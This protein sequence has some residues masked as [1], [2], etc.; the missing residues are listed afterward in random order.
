MT[1]TLVSIGKK[2]KEEAEKAEVEEGALA[3]IM[4]ALELGGAA[5]N[6]ALSKDESEVLKG[7]CLLTSKPLVY[8]ANV[9]EDDLADQGASNPYLKVRPGCG[10]GARGAAE[11]AD[12]CTPGGGAKGAHAAQAGHGAATSVCGGVMCRSLLSW[13]RAPFWVPRHEDAVFTVLA[14][15]PIARKGAHC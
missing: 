15:L 2:S 5:R 6:V 11:P 13:G 7:L 8:A 10:A 9:A 1:I 3:R 14:T 12:A 4:D